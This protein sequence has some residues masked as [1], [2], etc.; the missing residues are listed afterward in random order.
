MVFAENNEQADKLAAE[1]SDEGFRTLTLSQLLAGV[2]IGTGIMNAVLGVI[3]ALVLVLA[4]L[5]VATT[6]I[7]A[8]IDRTEEIGIL[9]AVGA[10]QGDIISRFLLESAILGGVGGVIG[11]GIGVFFAWMANN[12]ILTLAPDTSF[13]RAG[14]IAIDGVT[15]IIPVII[16]IIISVIGALA[17]GIRAARIPPVI[18]LREK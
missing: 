11:V 13:I 10:R 15:L 9:R 8:T 18:A 1:L 2:S 7:T 4:L 14:I 16:G 12:Y 17:P 6:M 5:T 3:I